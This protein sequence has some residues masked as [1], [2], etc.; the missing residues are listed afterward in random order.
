[1]DRP[2]VE[3]E[4]SAPHPR[5]HYYHVRSRFTGNLGE[6]FDVAMPAWTPGSYLIREYAKHV[7]NLS[8]STG[9][10]P[11]AVIR[12]DKATWRLAI[13]AGVREVAVEYDVWAYEMT[14]RTSYL[15][16][17]YGII[18]PASIFIYHP[19]WQDRRCR[20]R[21]HLPTGWELATALEPTKEPGTY[22]VGDFDGLVDSPLQMGRRL[23]HHRFTVD[24]VPHT[25]VVAGLLAD[26]L[27]RP[28]FIGDLTRII[29]TA[30]DL[31]GSLPYTQYTFM[32]TVTGNGGGGLEHLNSANIMVSPEFWRSS[33]EDYPRLL[34]LFA[35]EYFHLWNV[36]RLRPT[37]FGPFDYQAEVYTSLLWA[38]EGITDY[39][40]QWLLGQ[41]R[42]VEPPTILAHWA[43]ALAQYERLPG[44][45][46]TPVAESSRES[47]IR[48]YR[49]D[50]NTPNVTVSYY[51]KGS[52]VGLYLDLEL[53]RK[54]QGRISLPRVL[55]ELWD[56]FGDLGFPE[57][58]YEELLVEM[59]GPGLR[60]WLDR[61]V[62]GVDVFDDSVWAELGLVLE[63][64]FAAG[65]GER[66]VWMGLTAEEQEGTLVARFVERGGPAEQAGIAPGDELLGI[67]HLRIRSA[68]DWKVALT[69]L[70]PGGVADVHVAHRGE[71]G[72]RLVTVDPAHPDDYRLVPV[73]EPSPAQRVR[74]EQWMGA[75]LPEETKRP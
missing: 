40:A 66:P 7:V 32:V 9:T 3:Y 13:P 18:S 48:L 35:H 41:S 49:P 22:E 19:D 47:W 31:F 44:R 28:G 46:V 6:Q 17:D 34:S 52:L 42:V 33:E 21:V 56:R 54:S 71:I 12:V 15:D 4:L 53:R 36:K 43:K 60:D 65:D 26:T 1:M 30:R 63:R 51:L 70:L 38:L 61:Y 16:G 25:V 24:G 74:F 50:A 75:A 10:T 73:A 20:V 37:V 64:G 59:G 67:D 11:V 62:H 45:L 14:V 5:S 69:H 29:E 23:T 55:R 68:R 39:F 8:A 27:P 58:A 72:E 2:S 57:S